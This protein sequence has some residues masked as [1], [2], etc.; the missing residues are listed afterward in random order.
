MHSGPA[1]GMGT[2]SAGSGAVSPTHSGLIGVKV[3]T[4][5][6]FRAW[7]LACGVANGDNDSVESMDVL[8]FSAERA[9][10]SVR[11]GRSGVMPVVSGGPA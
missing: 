7:L 11:V 8:E 3:V 9:A 2:G 6:L 10:S 4:V 1:E 5:A